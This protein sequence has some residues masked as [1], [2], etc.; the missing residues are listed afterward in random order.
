[1]LRLVLFLALLISGPRELRAAL[2]IDGTLIVKAHQ[3]VKL[4]ATGYTPPVAFDWSVDKEGQCDM[5][6]VGE[7]LYMAA[8]PGEYVVTLTTLKVNGAVIQ[9]EK[10][11][12]RVTIQPCCPTPPPT[13]P[14]TSPRSQTKE[15]AERALCR[16]R[17]GSSGCTATVIGPR[18][19]DGKWDILTAAHCWP[20]AQTQGT[21]TMQDGRTIRVRRVEIDRAA[22]LCWMVTDDVI[23]SLPHAWLSQ[24]LPPKDTPIWHAGYGIDRP[25][26]TERGTFLGG[27]DRNN[28]VSMRLSVSSGDSGGGIFRSD[29]NEVI[30]SV[31]CTMSRGSTAPVWGGSC[32]RASA[33]RPKG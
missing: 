31:C 28:Q 25:R 11:R 12:V 29:T 5:A 16:L 13:A 33:L 22:D 30:S 15:E 18:R 24:Q 8:P 26:N 1:M 4:K 17:V 9:K 2:A 19:K 7:N 6:E 32:V 27:P 14:P 21:V 23:E 3:L 20:A 10:T